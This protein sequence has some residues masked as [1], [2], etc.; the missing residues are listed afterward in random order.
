MNKLYFV[1]NHSNN[2]NNYQDYRLDMTFIDINMSLRY[3][4]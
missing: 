1:I 2:N 4:I 3:I